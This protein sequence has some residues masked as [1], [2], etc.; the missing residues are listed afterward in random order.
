MATTYGR[1]RTTEG[2]KPKKRVVGRIEKEKKRKQRTESRLAQR[3]GISARDRKLKKIYEDLRK[4][5]KEPKG[6]GKEESDKDK[7]NKNKRK[8]W[9]EQPKTKL[10]KTWDYMMKNKKGGKV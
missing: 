5:F 9:W 1:G 6:G 10:P 7:E 2:R 3:T 4:Y 8:K